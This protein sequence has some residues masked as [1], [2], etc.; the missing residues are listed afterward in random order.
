MKLTE[1]EQL[2]LKVMRLEDKN[3]ALEDRIEMLTEA[4]AGSEDHRWVLQTTFR[5]TFAE[6]TVL[7]AIVRAPEATKER[8]Y[9]A[10]YG[11]RPNCDDVEITIIAVFVCKI[12]KKIARHG[13]KIK[14]MWGKGY[15]MDQSDR[16]L[17]RSMVSGISN[18]A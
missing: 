15:M 17:V 16:D 7:S 1:I 12:N 10:L 4:L 2:R 6:A 8:I 18:A 9:R 11:A 14:N 13:I 5:L 3:A